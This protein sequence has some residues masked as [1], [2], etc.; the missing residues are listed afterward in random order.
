MVALLLVQIING[1][2][3]INNIYFNYWGIFW[4]PVSILFQHSMSHQSHSVMS[5]TCSYNVKRKRD[6]V[7]VSGRG[8]N[9]KGQF[10]VPF[11]INSG[12]LFCRKTHPAVWTKGQMNCSEHPPFM[13]TE[14]IF[15]IFLPI[16]SQQKYILKHKVIPSYVIKS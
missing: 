6:Y 8:P 1:Y 16:G 3:I 10:R 5:L 13:F 4:N 9:A 12:L 7:S 2:H 11:L 14:N 15:H